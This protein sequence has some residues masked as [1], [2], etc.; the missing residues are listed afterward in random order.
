MRNITVEDVEEAVGNRLEEH[1]TMIEK[2]PVSV[3]VL[4]FNNRQNG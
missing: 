1:R 2:I 4:T 3:Y